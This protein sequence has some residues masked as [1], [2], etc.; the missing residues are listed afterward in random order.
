MSS[1]PMF[2]P[3]PSTTI[4]NLLSLV[5][6]VTIIFFSQRHVLPTVRKLLWVSA[7]FT[8]GLAIICTEKRSELTYWITVF[9]IGPGTRW[10]LRDAP[11]PHPLPRPAPLL[12]RLLKL[13]GS[14]IWR[15]F[16]L[17][18]NFRLVNLPPSPPLWSTDSPVAAVG[19][20]QIH[21]SKCKN[22]SASSSHTHVQPFHTYAWHLRH[23]LIRL[24]SNLIIADI[25]FYLTI[26]LSLLTSDRSY[27]VLRQTI[28]LS[29][30]I[31][32][33]VTDGLMCLSQGI[34]TYSGMQIL[35]HGL[36]FLGVGSGLW[37]GEEWPELMDRPWLAESCNEFWG[38][39]W[40]QILREPI[41]FMLSFL[42]PASTPRGVYYASFFI[43]SGLIH[44][45]LHFPLSKSFHLL[46]FFTT[47]TLYGIG[48]ML[49]RACKRITGQKVG[50]CGGEMWTWCWL[51]FS[52]WWSLATLWE[53]MW[54]IY[55]SSVGAD[56]KIGGSIVGYVLDL[57]RVKA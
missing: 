56:G 33:L 26:K 38:R 28:S 30:G 7:L 52:T 31:P 47:F 41:A 42:L 20:S 25:L 4:Y 45:P 6:W 11:L 24:L 37:I 1:T 22:R 29:Y 14:Q 43:V 35:W 13:E 55:R 10:A 15:T 53:P 57:I 17:L 12:R 5:Q 2:S 46:P 54:E 27:P 48:C 9:A 19:T 8:T 49:E 40:H 21:P 18:F 39:R 34:S 44:C 23:H 36:A 3:S 50:G 32:P 51:G 16:D